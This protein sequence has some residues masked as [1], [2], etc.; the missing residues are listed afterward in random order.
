MSAPAMSKPNISTGT[1]TGLTL[2][3]TYPELYG[4]CTGA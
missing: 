4:C 2:P 1:Q 3:G